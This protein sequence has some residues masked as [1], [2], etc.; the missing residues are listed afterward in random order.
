[1]IKVNLYTGKKP[2]KLPIVMGVDLNRVSFIGIFIALVLSFVPDLFLKDQWNAELNQAESKIEALKSELESTKKKANLSITLEQKINAYIEQEKKMNEK[3]K[4]VNEVLKLKK[5]P[6]NLL[7]YISKNISADL[8]I[9]KLNITKGGTLEIQ[10]GSNSYK[11]IGVFIESLNQSIFFDKS[12]KL[13][14]SQ[15][16]TLSNDQRIE[17]FEISGIMRRFD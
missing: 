1:M 8:W 13:I 2:F 10:G 5:N 7:L 6:V 15:T 3:L 12:I 16:Q 11:S 9:D 4:A 17:T 14:K